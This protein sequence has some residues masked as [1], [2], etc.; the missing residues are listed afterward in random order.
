MQH[1]TL[2]FDPTPGANDV[3]R[4]DFCLQGALCFINFNLIC[5]M[6]RRKLFGLLIPPS[7]LGCV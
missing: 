6:Q 5:N 7:G 3:S 4:A 2:P 1:E